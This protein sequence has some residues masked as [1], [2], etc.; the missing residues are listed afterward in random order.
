MLGAIALLSVGFFESLCIRDMRIYS[1]SIDGRVYHYR[2]KNNLEV[3][4]IIQLT[5]GRWGAV[6]I[7][8]GASEIE[9]AAENLLKLKKTIDTE[10]MNEPSFLMVL[11]GTEYALQMKNGVLVVPLGCLKN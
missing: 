2:D 10:S 5:D 4:A 8:M 6:E 1:E 9:D 3:D 7:K 11:T